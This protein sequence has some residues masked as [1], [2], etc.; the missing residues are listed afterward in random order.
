M[1]LLEHTPKFNTDEA[2][3][4]ARSLYGISAEA[5]R[6]PS[7]RDQ[8]FLLTLTNGEKR[9]LKVANALEERRLLDA[10]N[11]AMQHISERVSA[12]PRL[13]PTLAGDSVGETTAA[14]GPRH[15]VRLISFLPGVPLG[16]VKR[17]S[18]ELLYNLG[19]RVGELDAA[20]ADFDHPAVHRDLHWDLAHA[21]REVNRH[22]HLIADSKLRAIVDSL[23]AAF[24]Q[25]VLPL[26]PNLRRSVIQNDANDYNVIV[27]NGDDDDLYSRNQQVIGLIDFGDMVYSYTAADLA[28]AVAYAILNKADPLAAA[29]PI[30]RGYHTRYAL[31]EAEL[32]ALFGLIGMRLCMSVCMA[33]YQ[34]QQRPDDAYLSIS[35]APIQNTLPRLAKIPPRL[36]EAVFRHACGLT[37]LPPA[38]TVREWLQRHQGGFAPLLG[39]NLQTEPSIVF[40]L[41]PASPLIQGDLESVSEPNLTTRLFEQMQAAGVS[42]G[43]GRYHEPRLIYTAPIFATGPTLSD[44]RRTLHLGL[45]L[46]AAAGTPVFAPLPGEVYACAINETPQDYGGVIILKHTPPD[47][48]DFFTLYGHLSHAS[49]TGMQVGQTIAKGEPFAALGTPAENGGWPPHL[50]VQIIT[51]LLDLD[52]DFP[53]VGLVSQ[54]E[55]WAAFSP[56]PNLIAGVPEHR[57]PPPEPTKAQTL[58]VRR[59]RTG[60]NLS[61]GYRHPL[62]IVRGWRQYLYDETGRKYLDAYNNVPHVGHCHPRVVEAAQQQMAVLNT[63]TRYLHDNFN[64][65][66]ERLAAT[67]PDPL[68]VCFFLNSASEANELAIRLAR[69]YTG[70]KDMIVLEGAYH[71]HTNALIDISPYKHD[72]PG[73]RGAPA[74]VHTAPI[75][76]GYRGPYKYDDAQAGQKYAQHVADIIAQLQANNTGPAGFIAESCPSVG[77]QIFFP[78]GYLAA[79]YQH[80]RRAGG[81]CIADEVQTGYGRTGTHFYAFEAQQV[82]PDMVVLGKPI[83]NGHPIAA[84]VTT[85]EIAAAFNNGMEF[86]STFGGNTVSCAVGLTVLMVAQEEKLQEHALDVG[87]YLLDKLRPLQD[88]YAIVGDVR[89]SGLFLGVELVRNRQTLEPAADEASFI[90]NRMQEHGIL[91]GTDG[92]LHNVIKIRP[93]MPFT[94]SNADFLVSL[95]DKIL[96]EDFGDE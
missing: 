10:E 56:D 71:G 94:K 17:H 29:A 5:K 46:F 12:C 40:D 89:G 60:R 66:A 93:P 80:V 95:L 43:I 45:D 61:L 14:A 39:L 24:E 3:Q 47:G 70:Q 13:F 74:W 32:S 27:G 86:F 38:E 75:A 84:L 68:T 37:P 18:A 62:K 33:A 78:E 26:L 1:P 41:S 53:G 7:E 2:A 54:R 83:G 49:V 31:T 6:L 42:V 22:K 59:R 11:A 96:A 34:Q 79:V 15:F 87:V 73:G 8:N 28:I 77:G 65:Y 88:N 92:P 76:D 67:L 35:Q 4:V 44:E 90:V 91:L 23:A 85:P 81:L 19:Q 20:L 57:F 36:A 55:V 69:T 25:N 9:V 51:D 58:A 52:C 64:R 16:D 82:I 50:H 30:V 48:P 72:G 63:N 21:R